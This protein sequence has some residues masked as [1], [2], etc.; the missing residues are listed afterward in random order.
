MRC[1]ICNRPL[2]KPT[3]NR[4]HADFDPCGVCLE[5]IHNVFGDDPLAEEEMLL[6]EPTAEELMAASEEATP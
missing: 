1:H 2:E 3:Y 4:Q 6:V 5:V